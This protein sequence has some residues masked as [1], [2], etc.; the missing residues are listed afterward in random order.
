MEDRARIDR[1]DCVRCFCCH[2]ICPYDAIDIK[3]T[4]LGTI[5]EKLRLI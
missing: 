3:R 5:L 1:K 2:E 4:A